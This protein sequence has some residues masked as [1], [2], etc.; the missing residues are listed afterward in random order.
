MHFDE[1]AMRNRSA[2][3]IVVGLAAI[4]TN[5]A[6]AAILSPGST[7]IPAPVEAEPTAGATLASVTL[8]FAGLGYTGTLTSSVISGDTS[9]PFGG[10]TFTYLLSNN[11]TSFNAINRMTIN[12]FTGFLTDASASTAPAA[13]EVPSYLDRD[14]TGGTLGVAFALPPLGPATLFPGDSSRLLVVQTNA[15]SFVPSAAFVIDGSTTTV[16]TLAPVPEPSGIW[17]LGLGALL[18]GGV[19]AAKRMRR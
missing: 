12:G 16:G 18:I 1:P 17:L 11:A 8:P 2:F 15:T 7:L 19:R 5:A 10:L 9:N 14:P 6:Q 3:L 13:G 4:L